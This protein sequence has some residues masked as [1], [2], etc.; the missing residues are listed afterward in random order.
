MR[1]GQAG[2]LIEHAVLLEKFLPDLSSFTFNTGR[3]AGLAV[4]IGQ[5]AYRQV[6]LVHLIRVMIV[7]L[8][9]GVDS[10]NIDL[11]GLAV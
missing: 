10:I 2:R 3:M 6:D 8:V 11:A 7:T 4:F 1:T 9:S 5:D